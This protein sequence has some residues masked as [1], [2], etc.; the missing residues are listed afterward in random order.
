MKKTILAVLI[1]LC[2]AGAIFAESTESPYF[3]RTMDI[4]KVYPHKAGYKI[5]YRNAKMEY[6]TFYV[7]MEWIGGAS[8]KAE[9][10]YGDSA[11]YPYFSI[12]WKDGTF[13]HI[14]LYLHKD[15]THLTW[16]DLDPTNDI[17]A[18][19]EGVESI[20]LEL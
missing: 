7:P 9:L 3:V 20:E 8:A 12:F 19:F 5:L 16:G 17:S 18:K 10:I 1:L 14:R 15:R 4:M 2:V 11:A 6:A 13:D